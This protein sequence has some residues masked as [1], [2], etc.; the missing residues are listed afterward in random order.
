MTDRIRSKKPETKT[1]LQPESKAAV[2][3][4]AV[5]IALIAFAVYF[6]TL[7]NG[8]VYDDNSQVLNNPWI[9]DVKHFQDIFSKS[10]WEFKAV[11][12]VSNYYRPLMHIIYMFNYH[13][14]GLS[15]WG[16]HLV[17]VLFHAVNSVLVFVIA[18]RLLAGK[19]A[20]EQADKLTSRQTCRRA[21]WRAGKLESRQAV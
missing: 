15:P 3:F 17:N 14:F 4:P 16:F 8:F 2:L 11:P 19:P 5:I 7:F 6:N 13:I 18:S 20:G 1:R 9:R 10:V 21:S 12:L